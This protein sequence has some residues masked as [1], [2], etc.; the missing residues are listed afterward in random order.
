MRLIDKLPCHSNTPSTQ[1]KESKKMMSSVC[2]CGFRGERSSFP[3]DSQ[4]LTFE[5]LQGGYQCTHL[6]MSQTLFPHSCT[7]HVSSLPFPCATHKHLH[8]VRWV[9][10]ACRH[11]A[12]TVCIHRQMC[13][14]CRARRVTV[15][16]VGTR[17][18][19]STCFCQALGCYFLVLSKPSPCLPWM[20][21]S[22]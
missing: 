4:I 1:H 14:F 22:R 8:P 18:A 10:T 13:P 9:A 20:T 16:A 21:R 12:K 7:L 15:P 11:T 6:R 3:L 19:L 2:V 17:M 5:K